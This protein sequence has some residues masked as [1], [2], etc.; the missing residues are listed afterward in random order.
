MAQSRQAIQSRIQSVDSTKKITKAMQLVAASKLTRQKQ[1][2]EENRE[3]AG[4]LDE[5]LKL[6]LGAMPKNSIYL[7]E[8]AG[9][10]AYVFVI[11]S[12]MGLCGGYNANIF[13]TIQAEISKEDRVVMIGSRGNTWISRRDYTIEDTLMNLTDDEAY[14]VLSKKMQDALVLFEQG[15]ISRIQVLYTHYKNTLTFV[16]TL[17]TVLPVTK[18]EDSKDSHSQMI[19]EP[20]KEE[21]MSSVIPM[22]TKS[23]LY[24]KLLESKTSEQAS[25]RMAMENATDNAEELK[26]DLELAFNQARQAAITQEITEIVGG[27]NALS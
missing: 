1:M 24:S 3:Y 13:K 21:M 14:D 15:E 2:M 17:E 4:A 8:N 5:L 11:T 7:N 26:A 22:V 27:A 20:G 9:K 23:S 16:P 6:V 10:P 25:R 12:D 19:F 18:P